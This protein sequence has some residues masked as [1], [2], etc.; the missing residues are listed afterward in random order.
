LIV[1]DP[2]N[3]AIKTVDTALSNELGVESIVHVIIR[4]GVWQGRALIEDGC[5]VMIHGADGQ[6][7]LTS[8]RPLAGEHSV[9]QSRE[10]AA[11]VSGQFNVE[12]RRYYASIDRVFPVYIGLATEE[13]RR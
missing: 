1:I 2:A 9:L 6:G 10:F 5:K 8:I 3:S 13:V 11:N 7:V 12:P 4:V